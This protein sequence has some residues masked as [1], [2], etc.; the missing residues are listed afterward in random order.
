MFGLV[1]SINGEHVAT[2]GED[3]CL[4]HAN[5]MAK[6]NDDAE[7]HKYDLSISAMNVELL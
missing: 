2:V 4:L 3:W 6:R 1:I 7:Q 5:I